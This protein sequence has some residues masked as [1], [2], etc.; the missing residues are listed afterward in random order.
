MR[1]NKRKTVILCMMLFGVLFS[2]CGKEKETDEA[3]SKVIQISVAPVEA[4]PT[5]APDQ[6]NE[7]A[8]IRN[9]NLTMVNTYLAEQNASDISISQSADN[10]SSSLDMNTDSNIQED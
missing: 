9:G 2:G 4:T 3:S 10:G 1:I 8:V 6:V 7:A 5:P